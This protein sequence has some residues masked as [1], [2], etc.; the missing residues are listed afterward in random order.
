MI[1]GCM[2][3]L[4]GFAVVVVAV[5][6]RSYFLSPQVINLLESLCAGR[7]PAASGHYYLRRSGMLHTDH[8][9]KR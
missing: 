7:T 8:S 6:A 2:E 5:G 9:A 4:A 1:L 3:P